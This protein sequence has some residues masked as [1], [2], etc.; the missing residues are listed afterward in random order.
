MR[1][2]FFPMNTGKRK[3]TISITVVLLAGLFIAGCR[4]L[5]QTGGGIKGLSTIIDLGTTIGSLVEVHSPE[6]IAVEGYGLVGG[7]SGTG[8]AECPPPIRS[9]LKRYVL[10]QSPGQK[11]DVEKLIAGNNTAVVW[12]EGIM[13]TGYKNQ[14]FDVKVVSLPGTQ[15]TSLQYG[16]LYSTELKPKGTFGIS[17]KVIASAKGPVFIDK[18]SDSE[19]DQ[20]LGYVLAGG[21]VLD[22]Y[23]VGLTL[24]KPDYKTASR[25]RNRINERFGYGTARAVSSGQIELIV[26]PK[27]REQKEKF[28]SLV[29]TT[30][31]DQSSKITE[32]RIKA[33][34]AE[35][36]APG[37]KYASEIALEAIGNESI[38]NLSVLL[39]SSDEQVQL[40]AARCLLNLG[41]DKGL[42]TL[43][44]IAMREDSEYR[45][46]AL[47]AV[48]AA[49][50]RNDITA[51]S[52]KLLRDPDFDIRLAAYEQ[53]RK[54]NDI[55]V[56]QKL[57]G[58]SFYLEQVEQT[59]Q[60][61]IFVS[62]SG[63]SRIVLF[64]APIYFRDNAFVQSADGNITIDSKAG[65]EYV[66]VMRRHSTRSTVIGPLKSSSKLS[67]IIQT[68]CEEPL[69]EGEQRLTGLGVSYSDMIAV[70]KQMCEKGAV[71]A[72][73]QAGPL[74]EI[75]LNVKK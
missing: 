25:I 5:S 31:L 16:W 75:A 67:D 44:E 23:S 4:G 9:Y 54:L 26:P 19:I 71:K 35:L 43:R 59:E 55:T 40:R 74:P 28:M 62:R 38:N 60:K 50:R 1:F 22:E 63:Q 3:T 11:I 39:N 8:S 69:K 7:L 10:T 30:F 14:S 65:Q 51:I 72:Q 21:K 66:S 33:L 61:A 70:L 24:H 36:G 47:E 46:E 29:K 42:Q 52:R 53:L 13:P 20:R 12:L 34:V 27:Y 49:A 73:F 68:L 2:G 45:I 18:I 37:D 32:A 15:T 17:T 56:T 58:R 41:S 57:I 48:A 64:G 6:L